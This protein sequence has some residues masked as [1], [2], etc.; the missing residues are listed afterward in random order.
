MWE[1]GG[2]VV[3]LRELRVDDAEWIYDACQD[4]EI[5]R[6]TLVPR[7]YLREHADSF[8]ATGAGEFRN[9]VIVSAE[10]RPVG[11][12]S[13][14][15][16]ESGEAS[17]GYWVAPWGRGVGAASAALRLVIDEL[18]DMSGV[19]AVTANIAEGNTASLRTVEACGFTVSC[20]LPL[21]CRDNDLAVDAL[22]YRLT[23]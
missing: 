2:V 4:A 19:T 18:R 10:P 23:L 15:S 22:E 6:W 13:V 1:S 16:I 7:P 3:R 12:I 9:W 11:M 14:H 5:Q 8:V 17:I 21:G 20:T